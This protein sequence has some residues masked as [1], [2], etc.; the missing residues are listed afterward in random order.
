[1]SA[2]KSIGPLPHWDVSSV[3]PGLESDQ[4]NQAVESLKSLLSELESFVQEHTIN[5][6]AP[7]PADPQAL[8]DTLSGYLLLVEQ[9]AVAQSTIGSYVSSFVSTDSFNKTAKRIMSELDIIGLRMQKVNILAMGWMRV[10]AQNPEL[11]EQALQLD[12]P[13]RT[14]AFF[15]RESAEQSRYQMSESE[16]TLASELSLSG[17]RGWAK[18]HRTLTSQAKAPFTVNGETKDMP[19]TMI[20]NFLSSPDESLRRQSYETEM[21]L[22]HSLEE[23]LAA[24]LNGIKGA[25]LTV[26]KRR[27]RK[28]PLHRTLDQARMDRETLE[29]MLGAMKESFPIFRKYWRKKAQLLGKEQLPWWDVLAPV[30]ASD[31]VYSFDDAR[32]FIVK[33]FKTFSPR[34]ADF[35]D[36]VFE[37]NWIDAEPRPGKSG[38][39]FCMGIAAVEESRILCNYDGSFELVGCLAHELG[40][41]YHNYCMNGKKYLLKHSPMTM[42]ET[43]SIFNEQIVFNAAMKQTASPGE[44]R[45]ILESILV[46]ASLVIVDISSRYLFEAEVFERRARSELSADD[47]SDIMLRAQQATYGDGLD[48]RYLNKYMWTWKGH[49]YI[50]GLSFYNF[51]YAFGHLFSL[52]LYAIYQQRG[53][54]FLP[55]YDQLL[56]ST[57]EANPVDL[58]LRFGIDI[59]QKSFWE[60]S[61]AII[62]SHVNR[63]LDLKL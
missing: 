9:T 27:G 32:K 25:S 40:H 1:M 36:M 3:F 55:E 37:K 50:P 5:A 18:L 56:A 17:A 6:D 59:R 53:D 23:P 13:A 31:T 12:T 11:L 44:E 58:A 10:V 43:A 29:T 42:A 57:G 41:A 8:A 24:C 54:E 14:Y 30:G 38:G 61:L 21:T 26:E 34:L 35:T 51:P 28:D 22:W 47:F 63:Y 62:E 60:N 7:A 33:Q 49:Y 2:E 52:G 39:A 16:E 45:A 15:V 48:Q 20:H 19:A 46:G 4:F